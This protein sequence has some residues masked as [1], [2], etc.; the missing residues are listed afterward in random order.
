MIKPKVSIITVVLNGQDTIEDCI[1]SVCGQSY[2]DIEY[3]IIDGVSK[4]GTLDIIKKYESKLN[5]IIS[6]PDQGIYDAMNKGIG[7]ATGDIIGILNSDDIYI[8]SEVIGSVVSAMQNKNT[9][10]CYGDLQYVK[11]EDT[12]KIV[13][14]WKSGY[15]SKNKFKYGWMPPH[16]TFF[17]RKKI[18]ER[19]GDFNKN[20]FI[21]AD[22]ELMLRFLYKH[23][24]S[25]VYIPR[26]LVKMRTQGSSRP[27]LY[28][29]VRMICEEYEIWKSNGLFSSK[30]SI[31]FAI[32]F[33]RLRKL[34]QFF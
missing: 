22:Y 26:V 15:F 10:T 17:V 28:N 23:E 2:P 19:Y 13:R 12:T 11:R 6:E 24:V 14:Y 21:A 18:Y 5:K 32:V 27:G 29:T 9:D 20:F 8:D 4:D 25:T 1:K 30:I 33:K 31:V 16:P 3:I 7:L 34:K